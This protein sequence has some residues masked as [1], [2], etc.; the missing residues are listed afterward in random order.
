MKNTTPLNAISIVLVDTR[1]PANIGAVAR[2]MTNMGL[3]RLVLVDPPKDNEGAARRL[4]A[5][6][7]AVL[8]SAAIYSSLKDAVADQT[9]VCGV[10][11]QHGKLRKNVHAP[12]AMAN[13]LIPLLD[14]NRI[15]VVFGSEVNGLEREH[16]ALCQEFVSIPSTPAFPSLNLSHAVMIIAYELFIATAGSA[17]RSP[18]ELA[19]GREMENFYSHL[20]ATLETIGFFDPG[21]AERM[22]FSLRQLFGRSRPDDR[23]VNILRGILSAMDRSARGL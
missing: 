7:E 1:T 9:L 6:A 23:E 2:A 21:N 20:Q 16:L 18:R 4:A 5:G 3:S 14:T 11:R 15:A 13:L 17:L 22:M 10:S 8:D 19:S 12:R